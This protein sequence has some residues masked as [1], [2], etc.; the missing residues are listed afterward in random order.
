MKNRF[1]SGVMGIAAGLLIAGGPQFLFKLCGPA[2]DGTWMRCRWTGQA[3][4][5]AGA[6]IAALGI[7]HLLYSSPGVRM[8]FSA[9]LS[10]SGILAFTIPR[11]LIGGCGNE[12]M[13]CRMITFPAIYVISVLTSVGFAANAAYLNA[14]RRK[15]DPLR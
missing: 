2:D 5:G 8:G 12:M 15:G 14:I 9:A 3:E 13:P 1:I 10:L 7:A 4:I 6:L 11:F